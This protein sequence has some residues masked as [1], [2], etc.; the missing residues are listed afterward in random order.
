MMLNLEVVFG[1]RQIIIF[2]LA[3]SI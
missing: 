2:S 3:Y 1:I